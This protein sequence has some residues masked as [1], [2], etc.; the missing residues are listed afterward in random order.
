MTHA[1]SFKSFYSTC[2]TSYKK[3]RRCFSQ[4]WMN[5]I[6]RDIRQRDEDE[7]ALVQARVRD[8]QP[9]R[10]Q[11]QVAV[12][13]DIHVNQARAPADGRRATQFLFDAFQ[14]CQQRRR[15]QA[16]F[17]FND[18]VEEGRLVGEAPGRR[19]VNGGRLKNDD[20]RRQSSDGRAQVGG[21]VAEI[22]AEGE[23]NDVAN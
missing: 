3:L 22:G 14:V 11:D 21:A 20:G 1:L 17:G 23:V 6:R 9:G 18:H 16:R 5:K 12:K 19:L 10:V 4:Q 13:E 2:V 15:F 8:D 7:G